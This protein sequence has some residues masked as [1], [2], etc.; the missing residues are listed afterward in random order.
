MQRLTSLI[1][2]F[3]RWRQENGRFKNILDHILDH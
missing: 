1:Y 3:R 2:V